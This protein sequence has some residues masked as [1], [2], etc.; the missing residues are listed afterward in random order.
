MC[1]AI[2]RKNGY[3]VNFTE[4]SAAYGRIQCDS[5]Y[6]LVQSSADYMKNLNKDAKAE[7]VILSGLLGY[8]QSLLDY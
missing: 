1:R 5:P 3:K 4:G 7:F 8:C 6:K 2:K